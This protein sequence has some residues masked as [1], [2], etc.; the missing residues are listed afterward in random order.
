MILNARAYHMVRDLFVSSITLRQKFSWQAAVFVLAVF[1][2][3]VF[4]LAV[5]VSTRQ[6]LS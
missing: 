5:L 1:V 2:L 3:A 6:S 4:V